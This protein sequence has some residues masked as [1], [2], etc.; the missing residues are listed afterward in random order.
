MAL[1]RSYISGISNLSTELL[2]H[3]ASFLSQ[4]DLLNISLTD[5]HLRGCTE[6]ELYR[7]YINLRAYGRSFKPFLQRMIE[8]PDLTRHVRRLELRW[9]TTLDHMNPIYGRKE[10]PELAADEYWFLTDAAISAGLISKVQ[11]PG[12][13]SELIKRVQRLL[14][15]GN[16][17]EDEMWYEY[18]Y[19]PLKRI[20]EVSFD[21]KFCQHL[22]AGL[23]DPQVALMIA[24]LPNIREI[25]LVGAPYERKDL[26]CNAPLN[27]L[28]ALRKFTA[29][30]TDSELAWPLSLFNDLIQSANNLETLG[31][32]GAGDWERSYDTGNWGVGEDWIWLLRPLSLSSQSLNLTQIM[33]HYCAFTYSNIKTLLSACRALTSFYYSTGGNDMGPDNFTCPELVELLMPHKSTLKSLELDMFTGWDY[34]KDAGLLPSL[35]EFTQLERL[36]VTSELS[37]PGAFNYSDIPKPDRLC[38]RLPVSLHVLSLADDEAGNVMH[39]LHELLTSR[40]ERFPHLKTIKVQV[41]DKKRWVNSNMAKVPFFGTDIDFTINNQEEAIEANRNCECWDDRGGKV[42][43]VGGMYTTDRMGS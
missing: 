6:P 34:D 3:I 27:Q 20:D 40:S 4:V 35:T 11:R 21:N 14:A 7:E 23:E 2:L 13:T 36:Y 26:V 24:L 15:D 18:I 43:W 42:K 32:C 29:H 5:K 9:W 30:A 1:H 8:R 17:N 10:Y 37:A 28:P 19:S 12:R 38:N 25:D 31:V 16:W 39:H 22:R 41:P 33:L